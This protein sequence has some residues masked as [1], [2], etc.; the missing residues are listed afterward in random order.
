[1]LIELDKIIPD[2]LHLMLR[3]TDIL[4]GNLIEDALQWDEKDQFRNKGKSQGVHLKKLANTICS[5]GVSFSVWG[6]KHNA[7]GRGS[8]T[9]DWT[10]LMGDDRNKPC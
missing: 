8:G 7:D 4:I 2:E 5:C 6:K 3:V 9:M 10:S 1:V